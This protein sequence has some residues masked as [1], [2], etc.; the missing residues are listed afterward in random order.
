MLILIAAWLLPRPYAWSR[1]ATVTTAVLLGFVLLGNGYRLR[2][3]ERFLRAKWE[4]LRGALAAFEVAGASGDPAAKPMVPAWPNLNAGPYL[5]AVR[6]NG[7]P[8]GGAR[9][10]AGAAESQRQA[11]DAQLVQSERVTAEAVDAAPAPAGAA[12]VVEQPLHGTARVVARCVRFAPPAGGP[13]DV[14]VAVRPGQAISLAVA[15]G[16]PATLLARRFAD[17]P[18]GAAGTI[19]GGGTAILRAPVDSAPGVAWHVQ[20]AAAQRVRVCPAGD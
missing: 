12:P 16:S 3:S 18:V 4:P 14:T 6:D 5:D 7:S 17:V 9:W 19:P 10:L 20:V 13:G 2:D 1:W 15:A 8:T 11:A